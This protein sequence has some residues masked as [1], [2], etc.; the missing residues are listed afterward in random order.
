MKY[1]IILLATQF[2]FSGQTCKKES[3]PTCIES[4]TKGNTSDI[5]LRIDEYEYNG[6]RVFYVTEECCDKFNPVYDGSCQMICAP[7]G[8]I[9]GKGDGKCPDFASHARFVKTI[10]EKK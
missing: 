8:G 5:P 4:M 10:W 7:S 1:I 2:L 9:T 6:G 3:L